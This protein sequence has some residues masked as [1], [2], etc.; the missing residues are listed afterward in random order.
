[1]LIIQVGMI[2]DTKDF[3]RHEMRT[4]YL[5]IAYFAAV[6]NGS[7]TDGIAMSIRNTI[8]WDSTF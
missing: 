6:S 7:F 1:M 2:F 4:A 8:C 3:T 5:H